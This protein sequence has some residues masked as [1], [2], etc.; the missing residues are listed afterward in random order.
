MIPPLEL[1]LHAFLG[2]GMVL[3]PRVTTR[4]QTNGAK[5]GLPRNW[6][7]SRK[8]S[9]NVKPMWLKIHCGKA[10]KLVKRRAYNI[11]VQNVPYDDQGST[12]SRANDQK[13]MPPVANS[14]MVR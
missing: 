4:R 1:D 10:N 9:Y 5:S 13:R 8:A 2:D 14:K 6:T 12:E 7:L 11:S 3:S